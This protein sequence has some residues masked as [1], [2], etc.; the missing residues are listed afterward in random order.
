[1]KFNRRNGDR[2][3]GTG[4]IKRAIIAFIRDEDGQAITEYILLLAVVVTIA[5]GVA[6][7]VM[8]VLDESVL[9]VGGVLEKKLK[10]GREELNVWSN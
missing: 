10:T 8:E 2:R 3:S 5:V 6:R 9:R 1:M 7:L 4:S